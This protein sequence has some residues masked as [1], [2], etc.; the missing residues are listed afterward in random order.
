MILTLTFK[1]LE[2]IIMENMEYIPCILEFLL[3]FW[4]PKQNYSIKIRNYISCSTSI[5]H[6]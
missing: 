4:D 5:E 6:N 1:H 2:L 3:F